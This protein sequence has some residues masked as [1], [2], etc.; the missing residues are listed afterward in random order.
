MCCL[1]MI[2]FGKHTGCIGHFFWGHLSTFFFHSNNFSFFFFLF[3]VSSFDMKVLQ[4]CGIIMGLGS[5]ESI[6]SPLVGRQAQ[7]SIFFGGI[8]L[9][10]MENYVSFVILLRSQALVALYLCFKFCIFDRL[11][12][13]EYVFQVEES[14]HLFQSC[15]RVAQ[16][17]LPPTIREIH[18]SFESWQ[19]PKPKSIS[20][21]DGLPSQHIFQVYLGR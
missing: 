4:V 18:L 5:W 20:T 19:L 8:S 17:S 9:L 21:F 10:S 11:V 16:D 2:F 1:L 15:L 6:Q 12:Q 3:F 14:P 7:L 13:E